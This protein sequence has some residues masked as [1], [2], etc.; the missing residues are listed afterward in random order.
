MYFLKKRKQED[1]YRGDIYL[2]FILT[3]ISNPWPGEE[4]ILT[5]PLKREALALIFNNPIPDSFHNS[6]ILM[7]KKSRIP[8]YDNC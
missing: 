5:F 6:T 7:L 2:S 4:R 1:N 3:A 8:V